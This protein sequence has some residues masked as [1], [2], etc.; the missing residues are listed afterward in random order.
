MQLL[1]KKI[2]LIIRTETRES[3]I[4]FVPV[5][6]KDIQGSIGADDI[7]MNSAI[8]N[9]VKEGF[10]KT[11]TIGATMIEFTTKGKLFAEKM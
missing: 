7:S 6:I 11:K 2:M 9:L 10:I 5:E 8:N 1:E 4:G 3:G